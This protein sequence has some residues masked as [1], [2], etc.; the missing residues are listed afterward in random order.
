MS[1]KIPI[2]EIIAECDKLFNLG[3]GSECGAYLLHW[4]KKAEPWFITALL[5]LF[6]FQASLIISA[7]SA[8]IVPLC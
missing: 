5:I 4:Q 6:Y 8:G 7:L 3:K 2:S 1:E